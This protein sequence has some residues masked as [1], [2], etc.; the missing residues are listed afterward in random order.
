M[1]TTVH[2]S[3]I[4]N[5]FSAP[6]YDQGWTDLTK[7]WSIHGCVENYREKGVPLSKMN[8]GLPWYGRSFRKATGTK[9]LHG[10]PD[11]I[12]FHLDEGS[13][14]YFNIVNELHRMDTYRH[15]KTAT[16]Y[17]VFLDSDGGFTSYD[18]PRAICDKVEYAL[19]RGMHGCK[20]KP[21]LRSFF[22]FAHPSFSCLRNA[23]IH[24][25]SFRQSLFGKYPE[26]C[27]TTEKR[28]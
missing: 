25:S 20:S 23:L 2:L 19:E 18:D 8:L 22:L 13:P 26:I 27:S 1:E 12:N 16:Q 7:R 4:S 10:G 11:D 21:S 3:I 9:Q 6:L 28:P 15:E 17:A 24:P 5:C 14:Q